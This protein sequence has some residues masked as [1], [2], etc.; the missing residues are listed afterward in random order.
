MKKLLY[1]ALALVFSMALL[2]GCTEGSE[3]KNPQVTP[4]PTPTPVATPE[5][6]DDSYQYESVV[7]L[8]E[9][10]KGYWARHDG[11][12]VKFAFEGEKAV[13]LS[14]DRHDD[15]V[16]VFYPSSIM[17]SNKLTYIME[18][19]YPAVENNDAYPGLKQGG[20]QAKFTMDT[21]GTADDYFE[22]IDEEGNSTFY[23]FAGNTT[24]NIIDKVEAAQDLIKK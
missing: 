11:G 6:E 21:S 3:S 14:Y 17:A 24:D 2:T 9:D 13:A 16:A 12:Y 10:M 20:A 19:E 22:L 15:I 1:I 8:W 5:P 23:V 7:T 4:T 18:G